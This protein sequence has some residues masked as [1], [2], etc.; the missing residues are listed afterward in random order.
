MKI[1][2]PGGLLY[3]HYEA[4]LHAFF[5]SL[6]LEAVYSVKSDEDILKRGNQS[7]VDEAC[8]PMK[9]FHGHV[10]RLAETCDCVAIPRM[11]HCEYGQ[12]ICPKF[13]GL[14]ELIKSA[15]PEVN[16][17]FTRPLHLN[18]KEATLRSLIR[19]GAELGLR[20]RQVRQ[21]YELGVENQRNTSLG[22]WDAG[23]DHQI[24]L[25]GHPYNIYDSF[26]NLNLV[27]KLHRLGVGVITEE[28]ISR[29][30]KKALYSGLIKQPYWLSFMDLYGAAGALLKRNAVDGIVFVSSFSCGT[31]SFTADMIR[32]R[33]QLPFL[34]VKVDE[35]SGEAGLE[36]R[37][38]AFCELL[39]R[40]KSHE[41]HI[42]Q[43][44]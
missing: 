25:A 20:E 33:F 14:P 16:T 12:S 2:I 18:R 39:E 26:A 43:A 29:P 35:Q 42:P 13:S 5:D 10:S 22:M 3:Y 36:T 17:A 4:F 6:P 41:A 32:N 27:D 19:D 34:V 23:Y 1:G 8:L 28:R 31:D 38:E 9:L 7:C 40:R 44:G 21:A 37:L 15:M 24:F 30:E 11:M